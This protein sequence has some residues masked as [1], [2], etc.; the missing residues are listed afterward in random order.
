MSWKRTIF[1]LSSQGDF[2]LSVNKI[3]PSS[4]P[5][6]WSEEK[7]KSRMTSRRST[8]LSF[9]S[10][11][12]FQMAFAA[13]A[14]LLALTMHIEVCLFHWLCCFAS[15]LLLVLSQTRIP[16]N[17]GSFSSQCYIHLRVL[18]QCLINSLNEVLLLVITCQ[19]R[20]R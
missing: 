6:T 20:T 7:R 9:L 8:F 5:P 11:L 14:A 17:A 15:Q 12:S 10:N 4:F 19:M 16:T 1:L 2:L 13:A 3:K 18:S